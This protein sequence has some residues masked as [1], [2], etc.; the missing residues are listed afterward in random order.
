MAGQDMFQI[1]PNK[2]SRVEET[3]VR[4]IL[5]GFLSHRKFF[6]NKRKSNCLRRFF[7]LDPK[8]ALQ[9]AGEYFFG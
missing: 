2:S 9:N 6:L 5:R 1:A 4:S 3:R 7:R 8:T